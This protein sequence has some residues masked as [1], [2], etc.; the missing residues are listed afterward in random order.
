MAETGTA[1]TLLDIARRL[2]PKGNI[3]T[4]AELLTTKNEILADMHFV[5]CNDGTSHKTTVRTG[6]PA[7]TWRKLNYGVP[8]GKSITAQAK[9]TT[10][11]LETYA[12]VDKALA[13]LHNNAAA[14]RLSEDKAFLESMNKE[15]ATNVFYGNE[16]VDAEKF[17]GL[18]SRYN[19]LSDAASS[20]NVMS[21]GGSGD[22]N[23][24][25]WLACWSDTTGHGL[26]P[27]G[28]K[29]GLTMEDKGQVT[30]ENAGGTGL[31]ME[32]YRTH[33]KWDIG[34]SVRDWRY[35]ARLCNIDV[36]DLA[37][38]GDTTDSSP[39]LLK[40]MSLMLDMLP[41]LNSGRLAFYM[42]K[43]VMSYLRVQL[44]NKANVWVTMSDYMG[45]PGVLQFMGIP[46]RRC[47]ALL[48]TESVVS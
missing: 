8:I 27:K 14:F 40:K 15:M 46:C 23:T 4:I 12:E 44:M 41:D 7:A 20:A 18:S 28:S 37:T 24:S 3:D 29:A 42:N 10:G 32:A 25:I 48:N 22:D 16:A 26:Y 13:D 34:L 38:A 11:M 35:F 17:T 47:D 6:L 45:K 2:D 19:A 9:D 36:S 30:V 1:V 39:N 33:Y 43:T 21:A 31:R 5:E